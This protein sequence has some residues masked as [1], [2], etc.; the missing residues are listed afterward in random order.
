MD[1][2]YIIMKKKYWYLLDLKVEYCI[3]DVVGFW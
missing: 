3:I 2:I 1:V